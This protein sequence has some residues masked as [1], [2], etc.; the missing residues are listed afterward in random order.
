MRGDFEDNIYTVFCPHS[1]LSNEKTILQDFYINLE[2]SAS[3]L[4]EFL[5]ER[6]NDYYHYYVCFQMKTIVRVDLVVVMLNVLTRKANSIVI[7]TQDTQDNFV[8]LVRMKRNKIKYKCICHT[9]KKWRL[10]VAIGRNGSTPNISIYR[11][12]EKTVT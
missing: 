4:L 1:T 9:V 6:V 5:A 11:Y 8:I 7:V 3:E 10:D 12:T 2:A